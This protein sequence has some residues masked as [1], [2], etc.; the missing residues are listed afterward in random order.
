MYT[1]PQKLPGVI[2]GDPQKP[3]PIL[4][5]STYNMEASHK[6]HTFRSREPHG[7]LSWLLGKPL[8][9][10]LETIIGGR[11]RADGGYLKGDAE[12]FGPDGALGEIWDD[13]MSSSMLGKRLR[14]VVQNYQVGLGGGRKVG[15]SHCNVLNQVL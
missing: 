12:F 3:V 15:Q 14:K 1:D 8:R 11:R 13:E 10:A 6:D 4:S 5:S 7:L 2:P 9:R